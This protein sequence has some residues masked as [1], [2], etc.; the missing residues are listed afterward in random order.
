MLKPG[1]ISR[2]D[3]IDAAQD[4]SD[5]LFHFA[6]ERSQVAEITQIA[7]DVLNRLLWFARQRLQIRTAPFLDQFATAF[8]GQ[9]I[10]EVIRQH[11]LKTR[12]QVMFEIAGEADQLRTHRHAVVNVAVEDELAMRAAFIR[13]RQFICPGRCAMR[14]R[15]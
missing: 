8:D 3:V 2:D 11:D 5:V 12:Q 13:E 1:A 15:H 14:S 6:A 4:D 9:P 7:A 10:A